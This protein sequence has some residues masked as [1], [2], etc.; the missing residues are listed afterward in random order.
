MEGDGKSLDTATI[1][2]MRADLDLQVDEDY[3]LLLNM[4]EKVSPGLYCKVERNPDLLP[5]LIL[6]LFESF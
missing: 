2:K 3:F 6:E 5:D 1:E 4:A